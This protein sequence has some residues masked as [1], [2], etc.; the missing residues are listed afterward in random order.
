MNEPTIITLTCKECGNTGQKPSDA[1]VEGKPLLEWWASQDG[2]C[3]AC[4]HKAMSKEDL[5]AEINI[6]SKEL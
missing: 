3:T 5:I 2:I 6:L 4:A 1:T